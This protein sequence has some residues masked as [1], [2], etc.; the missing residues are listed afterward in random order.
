MSDAGTFLQ[1]KDCACA[2]HSSTGALRG[3]LDGQEVGTTLG[4]SQGDTQL[5]LSLPW[6]VTHLGAGRGCL[7]A[8]APVST[9]SPW[10]KGSGPCLGGEEATGQPGPVPLV[11]PLAAGPRKE[12]LWGLVERPQ[13]GNRVEVARVS[14]QKDRPP[15]KLELGRSR[16]DSVSD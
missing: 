8:L 10:G 14:G 1:G 15:A 5:F 11:S 6:E 9:W 3:G 13:M 16:T 2:C 4:P 12:A 7:Q